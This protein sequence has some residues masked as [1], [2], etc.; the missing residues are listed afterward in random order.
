MCTFF[1]SV[2]IFH[3]YEK[4]VDPLH[5]HVRVI[6]CKMSQMNDTYRGVHLTHGF[7]SRGLI[8]WIHLT[9]RP[10]HS[11]FITI[12]ELLQVDFKTP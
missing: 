8:L 4:K 3:S 12:K 9:D 5:V 2:K 6:I 10:I 1:N 7:G 11:I